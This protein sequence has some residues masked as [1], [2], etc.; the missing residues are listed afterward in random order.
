MTRSELD[1]VTRPVLP[2]TVGLVGQAGLLAALAATVGLGVAGWLAG[3]GYAL[4]GWALLRA[5]RRRPGAPEWGPA[6][7]VTLIRA[8]LAGG[9]TALVAD[10]LAGARTPMPVLV[11]LAAAA[12]LLDA[13]D[14][15][16]A[17]RTGTASRLGARFDVETDSILMFVLSGFVALGLG[18][19]V[20]A[21]GGF[22]YAFCA[23]G[24]GVPWLRGPVPPRRSAKV[25]AA[26]QGTGLLVASTGV[27]P[28]ALAAGALGLVLVLLGWSFGRDVGWLWRRRRRAQQPAVDVAGVG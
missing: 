10:A 8:V 6:D 18:W 26:I 25:V 24:W 11:A 23:A 28:R 3:A 5:A 21:V 15:P 4:A 13:A 7:T 17:R 19:W 12:L 2:P 27:L 16:V 20:L 1:Q 14:G 9:V 22:R